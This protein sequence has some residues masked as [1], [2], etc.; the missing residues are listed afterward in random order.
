[1]KIRCRGKSRGIEAQR[2]GRRPGMRRLRLRPEVLGLED[3]LLLA[4]PGD[5]DTSFG[6]GGIAEFN[7]VPF[8]Q[9]VTGQAPTGIAV[10]A[11]GDVI[12]S[13]N[14]GSRSAAAG[15]SAASADAA[16]VT[17]G[18]SADTNFGASGQVVISS[19]I[20]GGIEQK[21]SPV[22]SVDS[23]VEDSAG[24]T[25]FSDNTDNIGAENTDYLILVGGVNDYGD[26]EASLA[27]GFSMAALSSTAGGQFTDAYSG[28]GVATVSFAKF[29]QQDHGDE[30]T[31]GLLQ[32]NGTILVTGFSGATDDQIPLARFTLDG[33]VDTSFAPSSP[34][35]GTELLNIPGETSNP[36][37]SVSQVGVC[38]M[39]FQGSAH[40]L[41]AIAG[42]VGNQS[43]AVVVRLNTSDDSIDST[44]GTDGAV[45]VPVPSGGTVSGI[46]VDAASDGIV[47]A[48]S[49]YLLALTSGGQPDAS[50]GTSSNGV[51]PIDEMTVNSVALEG[52]NKIVVA[53]WAPAS[54]NKVAALARYTAN[55]ALDTTFGPAGSNGLVTTSFGSGSSE[56]DAV[57]MQSD[58]KIIA[59]GA[60]SDLS[61]DESVSAIAR[62]FGL[63]PE[64]TALSPLSAT[65]G[66]SSVELTVTGNYFADGSAG[67]QVLWNG[68][69]LTTQFVEHHDPRR[70]RSRVRS[71]PGEHRWSLCPE[72]WRHRVER[73]D[74]HDQC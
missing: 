62:Y 35:P 6:S 21:Q 27:P 19:A 15:L 9:S 43:E 55:G 60:S 26:A 37:F 54:G 46:A 5:L 34:Q 72:P 14:V 20:G 51:V 8:F 33:N 49:N 47:V 13:G 18:G 45:V 16:A 61:T 32:P 64:I 57:A 50:F 52:D 3:R 68:T 29:D 1:M 59:A 7:F 74:I 30:A 4:G 40:I 58:G 23:I 12:A 22:D 17:S 39:A 65:V 53:G 31:A 66:S 70:D 71:P 42:Q 38:A 56:Y 48:G 63:A 10:D 24:N 69:A 11:S 28:S 67:S 36:N 44:F 73:V 41:L 2:P 25:I